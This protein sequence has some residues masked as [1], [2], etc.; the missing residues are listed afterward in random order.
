MDKVQVTLN[1][2]DALVEAEAVAWIDR[3]TELVLQIAD[4]RTMLE[5][6]EAGSDQFRQVLARIK[7]MES[8][9][10]NLNRRIWAKAQFI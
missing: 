5:S 7:V 10:V 6:A 3:K 4:L 1:G 9:L 8:E 2:K